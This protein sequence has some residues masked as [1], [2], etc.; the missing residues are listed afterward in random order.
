MSIIASLTGKTMVAR[1]TARTNHRE[2]DGMPSEELD[3]M[4]L[5][6]DLPKNLCH[7][8]GNPDNQYRER[9]TDNSESEE[10]GAS[11]EDHEDI[12]L[13]QNG[14]LM[15]PVVNTMVWKE[16]S[17]IRDNNTAARAQIYHEISKG[18]IRENEKVRTTEQEVGKEKQKV[19]TS[20]K[21]QK[22]VICHPKENFEEE[23]PLEKLAD[24]EYFILLDTSNEAT[25]DQ[26]PRRRKEVRDEARSY[27]EESFEINP[28]HKRV[29]NQKK[30]E[31]RNP[32]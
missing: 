28:R 5:G 10:K 18:A 13:T 20:G 17:S 8:D 32:A 23:N 4:K 1:R 9:L 29:E 25:E 30:N 24:D 14:G 27:S 7:G 2:T 21:T 15:N 19:E 16:D 12:H 31:V 6:E 11:S 26:F 22:G 3:T